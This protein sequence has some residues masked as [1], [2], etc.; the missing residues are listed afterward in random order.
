MAQ[1]GEVGD[2]HSCT[3]QVEVEE[4]AV[5]DGHS[6]CTDRAVAGDHSCCNPDGH[7]FHRVHRRILKEPTGPRLAWR[8]Y[9]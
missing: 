6:G 3:G 7:I 8:F 1:E 5:E 9:Q 2:C 4:V